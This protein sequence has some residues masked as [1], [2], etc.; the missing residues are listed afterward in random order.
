M[1]K[2]K[3]KIGFQRDSRQTTVILLI[4]VIIVL[5]CRNEIFLPDHY[6]THASPTY[7]YRRLIELMDAPGKKSVGDHWAF[8]RDTLNL[9]CLLFLFFF[10]PSA[11]LRAVILLKIPSLLIILSLVEGSRWSNGLFDTLYDSH[12]I[13]DQPF[14][15]I[16]CLFLHL[17]HSTFDVGRSM[18]DVHPFSVRCSFF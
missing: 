14:F 9:I 6:T 16:I 11:P 13:L 3:H 2:I 10:S 4:I 7:R 12:W 8:Q 15:Q 1:L 17:F 18:F 5:S